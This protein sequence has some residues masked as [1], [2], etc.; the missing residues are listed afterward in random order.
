MTI[1]QK[2][3]I[4]DFL[5]SKIFWALLALSAAAAIFLFIEYKVYVLRF[6][7]YMLLLLC[8]VMHIFMHRHHSG[9]HGDHSG[10]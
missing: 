9:G 7:P 10:E 5:K 4:G 3:Q 2:S 6:W 8:P 1:E